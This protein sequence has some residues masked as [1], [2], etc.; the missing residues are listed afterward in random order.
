MQNG[1]AGESGGKEDQPS[2]RIDFIEAARQTVRC[3][4]VP[5]G[6]DPRYFWTASST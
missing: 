2:G 3:V 1:T 4:F 6:D 5:R